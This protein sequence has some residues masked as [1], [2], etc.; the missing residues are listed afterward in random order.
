MGPLEVT[1]KCR[2]STLQMIL[3][4]GTWDLFQ[5]RMC[6]VEKIKGKYIRIENFLYLHVLPMLTLKSQEIRVN[7]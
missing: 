1:Q 3:T 5:M 2:L 6:Y 7:W 4:I